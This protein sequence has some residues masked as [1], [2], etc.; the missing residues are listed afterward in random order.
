VIRVRLGARG[1]AAGREVRAR[2]IDAA[3]V[4][5]EE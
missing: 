2:V 5:I 4:A 1:A 3:T